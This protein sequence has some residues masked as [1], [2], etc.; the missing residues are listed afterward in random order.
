MLKTQILWIHKKRI[1]FMLCLNLLFHMLQLWQPLDLSWASSGVRAKII[2]S[3]ALEPLPRK[4][5][6]PCLNLCFQRQD[7]RVVSNTVHPIA[8]NVPIL[9]WIRFATK[10]VDSFPS[11][12]IELI[13]SLWCIHD[14]GIV[15]FS[16][17]SKHNVEYIIEKS[18]YKLNIIHFIS[19]F[20]EKMMWTGPSVIK[21]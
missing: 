19:V 13:S 9:R 18:S 4:K 7:K 2:Q 17:F 20:Q 1:Y 15:S 3:E 8:G 11:L 16:K 10:Q 14:I 21:T 6:N 5:L 12:K